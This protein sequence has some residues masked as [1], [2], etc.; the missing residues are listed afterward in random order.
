[1]SYA[2]QKFHERLLLLGG[3]MLLGYICVLA[4]SKPRFH[5]LPSVRGVSASDVVLSV[6]AYDEARFIQARELARQV[7]KKP[8]PRRSMWAAM[9]ATHGTY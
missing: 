4:D 6:F 8:K 2:A 1:M 9:E 7:K 5:E 3:F